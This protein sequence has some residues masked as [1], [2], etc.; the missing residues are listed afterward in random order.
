MKNPTNITQAL[1]RL[2]LALWLLVTLGS[3][4]AADAK[5]NFVFLMS[6][7]NSKHFMKMFD[8]H[9]PSTPNIES[10]AAQGIA[11]DRAFCNGPVCS[12]ARST[13]I[14]GSHAPR[15]GTQYHRKSVT[16]PMPEGLRMFPASLREAGYF[17]VT[18][19]KKD[20]NATEDAG[21][22][23]KSA[24]DG[25]WRDRKPGQPFFFTQSFGASHESALHFSEAS[26]A[27]KP[28]KTDPATVFVP[29][30]HPDTP[31]FRYTYAHYH[32]RIQEMDKKIGAVVAALEADGLLDDTFVFYF[33]DN[34]GVLPGSKGFANETGLH[35]PLVVRIPKNFKH[36]VDAPAGTRV[37]GFVSFV[38][39]GPTVLNLAGIKTPE[40]MDGRPFLGPGITLAEVNQ[41]D[42]TFGYADRFD[43]KTDLVRTLR[44]GRFKYVRSYQPF[45][46]DGL[47]NNYRYD[48][49]ACREWRDLYKAGKLNAVQSRFFEPRAA[50]ALYDIDEDPYETR[51]LAGDPAHREMLANLRGR[52]TDWVKGLPDLSF[53]PES[54]LAEDAFKNPV[55]FGQAHKPE[56]ARLVDIADLA[57][58]PFADAQD[59]LKA[60]LASENPWERY[61]ALIVCSA[62]GRA[63]EPLVPAAQSLAASDPENLVRVRAAEFLG[64]I[65]KADPRPVVMD[66]LARADSP[67]DA[68]LILNTLVLLRDGKPGYAFELTR[69]TPI[70]GNTDAPGKAIIKSRLEYLVVLEKPKPA[71]QKDL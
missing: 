8:P 2:F 20:Y 1:R 62:H 54:R 67:L 15:I 17:T 49:L 14:T 34:G 40:T 56:I 58:L 65:G 47:H 52:L 11:F 38:D 23:N 28:T 12:V 33:G 46:F 3:A 24:P 53:Y 68:G 31:T 9:G 63:A 51:N 43:E 13:L 22:W 32:D 66:A 71:S 26:M 18:N 25:S 6:E 50:E 44:K 70:G 64:L 10:L 59:R 29:P 35:V 37:G 45:N 30:I 69:D 48:T 36:L 61:W 55:A 4:A 27:Q 57:L 7:D 21:V 5:P 19:G 16:V 39:F 41:R 60:A 42:E